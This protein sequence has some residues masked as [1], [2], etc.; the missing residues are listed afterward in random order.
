MEEESARGERVLLRVREGR[1]SALAP[2]RSD[3]FGR[4]EHARLAS[5]SEQ[6]SAGKAG[7]RQAEREE[8]GCERGER[9]RGEGAR[10]AIELEQ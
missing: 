6:T 7:A 2:R 4:L 3:A 5:K 10:G 1:A 8:R 9:V